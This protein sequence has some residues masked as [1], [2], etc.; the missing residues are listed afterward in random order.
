METADSPRRQLHNLITG[1]D[2][3]IGRLQKRN[4]KGYRPSIKELEKLMDISDALKVVE[5]KLRNAPR[6]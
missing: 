2:L 1:L 4:K 5:P 6:I 3:S